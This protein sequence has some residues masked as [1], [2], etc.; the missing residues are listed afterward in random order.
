[1]RI[2][3]ALN[4]RLV[5][6]V[7]TL[8]LLQSPGAAFALSAT[9]LAPGYSAASFP[10]MP[11]QTGA[12][13][14]QASDL[15]LTPL[16]FAT[17]NV[18]PSPCVTPAS[19]SVRSSA[20]PYS[21][22]APAFSYSNSGALG[23]AAFVNG[24]DFSNDSNTL[25]ASESLCSQSQGYI[26]NVSTG[27]VVADLVSYRPTGI[28]ALGDGLI[29]FT[30]RQSGSNFGG[31][32]R[33]AA[34]VV[35][36]IIPVIVGRGVAVHPS[37]DIYVA[38]RGSDFGGYLANS[39]YRFPAGAL[40]GTRIATF[41]GTGVAELTFDANGRLYAIGDPAGSVTPVVAITL[42]TPPATPPAKAVPLPL[43]H[44][45]AMALVLSGI[46]VLSFRRLAASRD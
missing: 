27:V 5:A 1:M 41:D 42:P 8:C 46:G 3:A 23:A 4:A 29:Y 37:G 20:S 7:L 26:R 43:L 16:A 30:A 11:L 32:Y 2:C 15:S 25:Y 45:A 39:V 18:P 21:T 28:D 9:Y 38:T 12:L 31:V 36:E 33:W 17:P 40:P 13:A 19:F 14:F 35:T 24:L 34:G 10:N 44:L 6:F 22:S